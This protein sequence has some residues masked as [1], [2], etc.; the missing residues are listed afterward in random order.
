MICINNMEI[1]EEKKSKFDLTLQTLVFLN[2]LINE[3]IEFRR[4]CYLNGRSVDA[5]NNWYHTLDPIRIEIEPKLA[6]DEIKEIEDLLKQVPTMDLPRYLTKRINKQGMVKL[7]VD[8]ARYDQVFNIV[9]ELDRKIRYY[10]DKHNMRIA[11]ADDGAW[12]MAGQR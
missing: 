11:S 7:A 1:P 8:R 12:G 9:R 3:A 2:N 4:Q 5:L 6:K 10:V